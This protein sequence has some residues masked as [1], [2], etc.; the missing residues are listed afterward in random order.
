MPPKK[1]KSHTEE[2]INNIHQAILLSK[3]NAQKQSEKPIAILAKNLKQ[4]KEK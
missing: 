3:A 2:F 1:Y 4:K